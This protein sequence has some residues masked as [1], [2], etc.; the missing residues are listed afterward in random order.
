FCA[1][2]HTLADSKKP[3]VNEKFCCNIYKLKGKSIKEVIECRRSSKTA[4][5]VRGVLSPEA[6]PWDQV[7]QIT[8]FGLWHLERMSDLTLCKC[9]HLK[10]FLKETI[11]VK[12][13]KAFNLG[14]RPWSC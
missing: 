4:I 11:I 8:P 14:S 3:A 13:C 12:T 7:S 6:L 10:T 2:S 1:N 9:G 5:D